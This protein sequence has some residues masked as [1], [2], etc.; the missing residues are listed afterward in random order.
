MWQTN[1]FNATVTSYSPLSVSTTMK[2]GPLPRLSRFT[3]AALLAFSA[4]AQAIPERA[5]DDP[6]ALLARLQSNTGG[7]VFSASLPEQF[8]RAVHSV[9]R[10]PLLIDNSSADAEERAKFFLSVYGSLFG[11][12]DPV[13]EL[14]TQRVS[15]DATGNTHVH[16]EQ[17]HGGLP[18]FGSRLVVHMNAEGIIG[19]NGVF[20]NDLDGLPTKA[21]LSEERLKTAALANVRKHYPKAS[22]LRV[23]STR[24]MYYRTGLLKGV[25]GRSYLAYEVTVRGGD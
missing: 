23:E 1:C 2:I 24:L 13:A 10:E 7:A 16:L 12:K 17:W 14:R 4:T 6:K 19:G 21:Q 3:A 9:G 22:G 15:R 18:V 11:V 5:S 20:A 25:P 8:Y